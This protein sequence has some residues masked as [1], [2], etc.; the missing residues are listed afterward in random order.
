MVWFQIS[1]SKNNRGGDENSITTTYRDDV[2]DQTKELSYCPYEFLGVSRDDTFKAVKAAY[3]RLCIAHHPRRHCTIAEEDGGDLLHA[4]ITFQKA[5]DCLQQIYVEKVVIDCCSYDDP[6][7][8]S[9]SDG[10]NKNNS[11]KDNDDDIIQLALPTRRTKSRT[12]I[13]YF[14]PTITDFPSFDIEN[15]L[16]DHNYD[17]DESDSS[18]EEEEAGDEE[19][20]LEEDEYDDYES[21]GSDWCRSIIG[22]SFGPKTIADSTTPSYSS[23][24]S[25]SYSSSSYSSGSSRSSGSYNGEESYLSSSFPSSFSP[26]V[27]S[28]YSSPPDSS[29]SSSLA[30]SYMYNYS[31]SYS[32]NNQNDDCNYVEEDVDLRFDDPYELFERLCT[33]K[34]GEFFT[35]EMSG[36]S[37]SAGRINT[38]NSKT[39]KDEQ[40]RKAMQMSF[41]MRTVIIRL[42]LC[43]LWEGILSRV[44]ISNAAA[45]EHQYHHGGGGMK[46]CYCV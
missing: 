8:P 40:Q 20:T 22:G 12:M 19:Y 35:Q 43:F 1:S 39:T 3:L 34:Y 32:S 41:K 15:V 27:P 38:S 14:E 17:E 7:S 31:S 45:S 16:R 24:T 29:T 30:L 28:D 21:S 9:S 37:S 18:E 4:L 36:C 46:D 23:V 33:E 11:N 25:N 6:V 2:M 13:N 42:R 44:G 5:C 26:S 10:N